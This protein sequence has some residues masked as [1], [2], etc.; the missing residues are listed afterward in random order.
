M[1]RLK[2]A[3][4]A[5]LAAAVCVSGGPATAAVAK[6]APEPGKHMS[7][8]AKN[9]S[10]DVVKFN[11]GSFEWSVVDQAKLKKLKKRKTVQRF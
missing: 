3:L 4:A 1:K 8:S 5:I 11:T 9:T 6:N 7:A 2:K 10:A